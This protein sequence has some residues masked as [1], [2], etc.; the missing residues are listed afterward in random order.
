[1][2]ESAG[3]ALGALIT[4]M[5]KNGR[6]PLNVYEKLYEASICSV[7]DYGGEIWGFKEY[8]DSRKIHLRAIRAFLGIP[9]RA[10]IPGV[11]AEMNWLDPRSRTQIRMIRHFKRLLN[12]Q[13]T[14]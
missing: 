5:I 10:P 11:L 2:A 3:R 1:M 9:K 13:T 6:F 7:S 14:D 4:E 8:E 12:F